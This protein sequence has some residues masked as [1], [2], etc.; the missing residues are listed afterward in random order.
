M[1]RIILIALSLTLVYSVHANGPNYASKRTK[2]I[3]EKMI[4]AHGGYDKWKSLETLTFTSVMHSA[5]LPTLHFWIKT[6]VVDMQDRRTYQD[7][8]VVG[9]QLGFDG[10]KA[11]GVN[12]NVG[13]PPN[14]QHSVFFYYMNL[15]WLTQDEHVE[16]GEVE[17][18]EHKAFENKVYKVHM[19]YNK[20]PTV[21]KSIRDTYELFIDSESFLL[22]GYEYTVG[23]GP[24]LDIMG[25]PREAKIFGPMF[26]KNDYFVEIEGLKYAALF[27][28][29]A[30]DLSAQYGD[31]LLYDI[32]VN[33]PFDESRMTPPKNAVIDTSTDKRK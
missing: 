2:E 3:I 4:M 25:M 10:E 5:S 29:Y 30:A 32:K 1:K 8:P 24:M 31:H 6:Q 16:L 28:T 13:N 7:W 11:W 27:T 18:V 33:E 19:S 15:P 21:G 26:R 23:W 14:H 12:W 9:S 20:Q 22:V 17:L